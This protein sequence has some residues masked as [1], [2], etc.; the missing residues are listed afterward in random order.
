MRAALALVLVLAGCAHNPPVPP[1]E[2][3]IWLAS[4]GIRMTLLLEA[5]ASL[6]RASMYFCATK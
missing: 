1:I 4:N 6:P 2:P 3:I 5:E